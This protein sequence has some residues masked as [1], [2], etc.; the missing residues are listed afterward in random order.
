MTTSVRSRV[1]IV[2]VSA[3]AFGVGVSLVK[4]NGGGVR[5]A[6]GNTSAPWLLL[7]FVAAIYAR[8]RTTWRGV[9]IGVAASMAAL[10]GFYVA[11]AFVLDLGAHSWLDDISLTARAGK[12]F[13]ALAVISGPCFGALGA[14][15]NRTRSRWLAVLVA[16]L[17]VVEPLA[18]W[19][20]E[21]IGRVAYADVIAVWAGE[22][23]VG[24]C[25][26]VATAVLLRRPQVSRS[27]RR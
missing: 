19:L 1:A 16:G 25:A 18:S 27:S 8:T 12:L 2:G 9:L 23:A 11:N 7:P 14:R 17:L 10:C 26:C 5:D 24:L 22:I 13:F 3:L 21:L 4:G 6:I 15:W 20:Y